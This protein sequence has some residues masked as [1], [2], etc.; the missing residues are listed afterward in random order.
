MYEYEYLPLYYI[1]NG[2]I[3][4]LFVFFMLIF[5]NRVWNH[6]RIQAMQARRH[7]LRKSIE[8]FVNKE[9]LSIFSLNYTNVSKQKD[10]LIVLESF[11]RKLKGERWQ[12]IKYRLIEQY[13][14]KQAKRYVNSWFWKKRSIAARIYVLAPYLIGS[15]TAI[16]SLCDR[17]FLVYSYAARIVVTCEYEK[18]IEV[19]IDKMSKEKGYLFYYFRDLLRQGSD[20]IFEM[21]AKLA[22]KPEYRLSCL[23]ILS[24]TTYNSKIENIDADLYSKDE[25]IRKLAIQYIGHHP[26]ETTEQLLLDLSHDETAM[27]RY[28]AIK[29]LEHFATPQVFDYLLNVLK[30]DRDQKIRICAAATL[31]KLGQRKRLEEFK[32]SQLQ[33]IIRYAIE[34][35]D[36]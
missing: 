26:T 9:M 28:M 22:S 1:L 21:V 31:I 29:Q 19:M 32:D 17:A 23:A 24:K 16:Q 34:F 27:I 5:I 25:E 12:E 18:G 13:L 7:F 8:D 10:L 30:N 3:F 14:V 15:D 6:F 36:M 2:E 11:E 20:K 35:G 33:P 4:L